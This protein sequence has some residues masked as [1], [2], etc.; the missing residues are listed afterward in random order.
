[1]SSSDAFN[2]QYSV[3][4]QFIKDLCAACI[5]TESDDQQ[6]SMTAGCA[7]LILGN[8]AITDDVSTALVPDMIDVRMLFQKLGTSSETI[9]LNAAAGLLRHLATPMTNRE[10]YFGDAEF[11]QQVA[12]L[13]TEATLDQV[14]TG[15]L[16]LIRQMISNIPER[17]E[18]MILE[19]SD[20]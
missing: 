8:L 10:L 17:A 19:S 11:L 14:Q 13:Y 12:H 20:R 4:D 9:F 18:G 5:P 7:C 1:M 6:R 2:K 16:Q 3:D 15:G